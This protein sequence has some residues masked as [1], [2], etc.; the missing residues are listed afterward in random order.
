MVNTCQLL[1]ENVQQSRC[2]EID[3]PSVSEEESADGILS[4]SVELNSGCSNSADDLH[5][6]HDANMDSPLPKSS[7]DNEINELDESAE[8][9]N[10]GQ[11]SHSKKCEM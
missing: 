4:P 5:I 7:D 9:G 6:V 11:D 2:N 3:S 1:E 8:K 10:T